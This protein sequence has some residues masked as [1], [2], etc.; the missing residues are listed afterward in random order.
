MLDGV[1]QFVASQDDPQ[2]DDFRDGIVKWGTEWRGVEPA[3]GPA[4]DIMVTTLDFTI[5]QTH[6]LAALFA[7][8]RA[9]CK[10]EQTYNR[11]DNEALNAMLEAYGFA[12]IIGKWGP[13]VSNHVR[14]GMVLWGPNIVYPQHR[15][16]AEEVYLIV[17]G[18]AMFTI[19]QGNEAITGKKRAGDV[20]RIPSNSLHGFTTSDEP[21]AILAVWLADSEDLR[22][23]SGFD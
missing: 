13:F 14:V 1:L 3:H 7:T 15:H 12:E 20:V 5:P 16:K 11:S 19:G 2:L 8:E 4:S 10:W 21:I 9:S 17:A 6:G 23:P 22:A 18:S